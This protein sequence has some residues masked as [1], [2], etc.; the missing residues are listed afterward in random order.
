MVQINPFVSSVEQEIALTL[1]KKT[2]DQELEDTQCQQIA[3]K[4]LELIP[5]SIDMEGLEKVL[6]KITELYPGFSGISLKYLSLINK[7]TSDQKIDNVRKKINNIL[8]GSNI[9]RN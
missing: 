9:V 1:I 6:P 7:K 5:E 4:I 3:K 8:Y 2:Y